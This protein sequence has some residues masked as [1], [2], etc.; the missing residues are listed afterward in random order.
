MPVK[1]S[2]TKSH[3]DE[4]GSQSPSKSPRTLIKSKSDG[5]MDKRLVKIENIFDD[6]VCQNND[7]EEGE[8]SDEEYKPDEREEESDSARS[9]VEVKGMYIGS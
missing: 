1:K 7:L 5:A 8:R 6:E 3:S 9:D 4:E 2:K